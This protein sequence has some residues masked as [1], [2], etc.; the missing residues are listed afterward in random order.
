MSEAPESRAP[1]LVGSGLLESSK[2]PP[3]LSSEASFTSRFGWRLMAMPYPPPEGEGV[4]NGR[5]EKLI[6]L[7]GLTPFLDVSK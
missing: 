2:V 5:E 6:K 1:I 4:E 7:D 3:E